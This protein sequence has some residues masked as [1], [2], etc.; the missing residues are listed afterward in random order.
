MFEALSR[1]LPVVCLDLDGP[2]E[3]ITDKCG[4]VVRTAEGDE[5][6]C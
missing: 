2:K 3:I 6:F 5:A 1:G 4:A